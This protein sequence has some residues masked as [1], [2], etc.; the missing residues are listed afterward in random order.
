MLDEAE[1]VPEFLKKACIPNGLRLAQE[2]IDPVK[3]EFLIKKIECAKIEASKL[4]EADK[5]NIEQKV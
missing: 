5:E 2:I 4:K 1:Q 3:P